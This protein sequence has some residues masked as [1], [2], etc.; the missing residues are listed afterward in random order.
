MKPITSEIVQELQKRGISL[1]Q[2]CGDEVVKALLDAEFDHD[3]ILKSID[4]GD[5]T[6][7]AKS[8]YTEKEE[9][10]YDEKKAG[11]HERRD[12]E[13]GKEEGEKEEEEEIEKKKKDKKD[14]GK[15]EG[16][17][18]KKSIEN[19]L[20]KSQREFFD[21][22]NTSLSEMKDLMKSMGAE[23]ETLRNQPMPF[24]SVDKGAVLEKSFGV[25]TTDEG[26]KVLSKSAHRE[27]LKRVMTECFEKEEDNEMKK[28]LANDILSYSTGT[29][30]LSQ[31]T[32][33]YLNKKGIEVV[34]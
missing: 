12:F 28:S 20:Y 23:I 19:D 29:M 25:K 5:I 30:S 24:R 17:E 15:S 14:V 9:I 27:P 34:E 6:T 8:K 16:E 1:D 33:D 3:Y 2:Y 7:F 18:M 21:E 4:N 32:I 31:A 13:E 26:K 11:E 22:V 10:E